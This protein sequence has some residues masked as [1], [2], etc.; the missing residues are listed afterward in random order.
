M[1]VDVK[2]I[3]DRIIKRVNEVKITL[4]DGY[5][6]WTDTPP[7]LHGLAD[8][9]KS[10]PELQNRDV[11]WRVIEELRRRLGVPGWLWWVIKGRVKKWILPK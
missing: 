10:I 3:V 7:I 8:V 11:L 9:I 6:F 5:Q 4:G 2:G 1:A